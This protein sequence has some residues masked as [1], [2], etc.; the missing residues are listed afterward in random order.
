[1][2]HQ[3][4]IIAALEGAAHVLSIAADMAREDGRRKHANAIIA[5]VRD[6]EDLRVR[7][8]E[9]DPDDLNPTFPNVVRDPRGPARAIRIAVAADGSCAIYKLSP[10][11]ARRSPFN[12]PYYFAF[13][14]EPGETTRRRDPAPCDLSM[15]VNPGAYVWDHVE[16][17]DRGRAQFGAGEGDE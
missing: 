10:R 9:F 7:N 6:V 14:I 13:P 3:D 4:E 15:L 17:L 11:L 5:V 12:S 2:T 8:E 1:M 16:E